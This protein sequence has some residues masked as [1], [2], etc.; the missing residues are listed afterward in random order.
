[1]LWPSSSVCFQPPFNLSKSYLLVSSMCFLPF[2]HFFSNVSTVV[3]RSSSTWAEKVIFLF[4]SN[5]TEMLAPSEIFFVCL[6]LFAGEI[7]DVRRLRGQS[8]RQSDPSPFFCRGRLHSP[9]YHLVLYTLLLNEFY[10]KVLK[11]LAAMSASIK[12]TVSW[13]APCAVSQVDLSTA[14]YHSSS[15]QSVFTGASVVLLSVTMPR[16]GTC[17]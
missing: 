13:L 8:L 10:Q 1:M 17:P 11:H 4:C 9:S 14:G 15:N 2:V 6:T 16:C 12:I 5:L 3:T 7:R